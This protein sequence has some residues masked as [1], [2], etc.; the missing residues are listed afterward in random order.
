MSL[1]NNVEG[2]YQHNTSNNAPG[3]IVADENTDLYCYIIIILNFLRGS[4]INNYTLEE[5]YNFLNYMESIGVSREL[6][7]SFYKILTNTENDN[8]YL[9]LDEIEP[10]QI[11]KLRTKNLK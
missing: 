10:Y 3:Y 9:M 7:Q 4:N 6:L 8:P 5:F 2:K 1:L 11:Y